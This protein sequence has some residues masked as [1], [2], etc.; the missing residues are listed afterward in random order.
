MKRYILIILLS[1]LLANVFEY[2]L[3]DCNTSS[4]TH[5]LNVWYPEYS[6]HITMHYFATQG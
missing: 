1:N 5:Q 2:S 6:N 3:L 4:P